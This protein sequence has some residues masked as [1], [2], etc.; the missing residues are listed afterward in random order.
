MTI[1][2][3]TPPDWEEVAAQ[4]RKP[5][6]EAGME[7]GKRMQES[8]MGMICTTIDAMQ[9]EEGEQI[10]EIGF[11]NGS[12]L[13]Y[14]FKQ[15]HG[16]HYTGV[17]MSQTM[18]D[19]TLKNNAHR[20]E[21][22]SLLLT[23]GQTIP[24]PDHSVD[25]VFTVNTIYFWEHPVA[26]AKEILRVI[27]PG[28]RFYVAFGEKAFMQQLPFTSYGFT[29]YDTEEAQALLTQAGFSIHSATTHTEE[30]E[31]SQSGERVTRTYH[32]VGGENR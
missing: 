23:D 31:R 18:L 30:L 10:L 9:I 20:Q 11:G 29:L 26:Y 17:D 1:E 4:L 5:D 25:R 32:V 16:I 8:N 7:T 3:N 22:F 6:G 28:G 24:L 15:A 14:L 21:R 2:Q 13:D 27:K 19:E 12:H